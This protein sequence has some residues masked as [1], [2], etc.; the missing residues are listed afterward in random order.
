MIAFEMSL[1][2]PDFSTGVCC[3]GACRKNFKLENS[4]IAPR[5]HS[6]DGT[7]RDTAPKAAQDSKGELNEQ[8][9]GGTHIFMGG[10][11]KHVQSVCSESK[12]KLCWPIKKWVWV[13]FFFWGCIL[14]NTDIHNF[15][16]FSCNTAPQISIYSFL[17]R[18]LY[19][20]AASPITLHIQS[21]DLKYE[22]EW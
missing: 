13:D 1:F 16:Y 14:L 3:V 21:P 8:E 20:T 7:V 17:L 15:S 5:S 4:G 22:R 12:A 11:S 6:E 19:N 18:P 10:L 2:Q 9:E